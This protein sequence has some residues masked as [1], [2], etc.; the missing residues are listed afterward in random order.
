MAQAL[1]N[2]PPVMYE[3]GLEKAPVQKF[4]EALNAVG[5]GM[6]AGQMGGAM[7]QALASKGVPALQ[8]LGEAGALFPEGNASSL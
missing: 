3:P 8:G 4:L 6:G 1:M 2:H 7:A 5:A